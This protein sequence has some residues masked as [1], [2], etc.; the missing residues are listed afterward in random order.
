MTKA[1][2]WVTVL[3]HRKKVGNTICER[4]DEEILLFDINVGHNKTS[5]L[6]LSSAVSSQDTIFFLKRFRVEQPNYSAGK[7]LLYLDSKVLYNL[8]GLIDI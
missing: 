5:S 7:Y 3:K 1:E 2:K 8:A 6:S 4:K